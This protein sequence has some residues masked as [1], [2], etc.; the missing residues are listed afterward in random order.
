MSERKI[1]DR[2]LEEAALLSTR[3]LIAHRSIF[4]GDSVVSFLDLKKSV[5]TLTAC[6]LQNR[7]YILGLLL[8]NPIP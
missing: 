1:M 5:Y 7:V 3:A 6:D 2:L 4:R 8:V